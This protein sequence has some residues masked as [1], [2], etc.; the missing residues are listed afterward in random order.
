MFSTE[1]ILISSNRYYVKIVQFFLNNRKGRCN[2]MQMI[3]NIIELE[4][5]YLK[6]TSVEYFVRITDRSD[7]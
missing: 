2:V 1:Q 4:L 7:D 6:E 5:D 3:E